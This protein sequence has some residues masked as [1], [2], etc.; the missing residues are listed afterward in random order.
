[1]YEQLKAKCQSVIEELR[2]TCASLENTQGLHELELYRECTAAI[3]S[4]ERVVVQID[5][6]FI[7][8]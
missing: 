1:M 6:H 8:R 5:T 3:K 7:G 4:A 2:E